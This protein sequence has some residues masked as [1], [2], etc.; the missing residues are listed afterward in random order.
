MQVKIRNTLIVTGLLL[1]TAACS[2]TRVLE[3]EDETLQKSAVSADS[4]LSGIPDYNRS[5]T[6]LKG[7]GRAIVSEPGNTERVKV[8][9]TSNR[10][11]SLVTIKNGLGI[12]GGRLLAHEDSMLIYNKVD[13]IAQRVSVTDDRLSSVNHLASVNI[14]DLM[15]F[16]VDRKDVKTVYESESNY[17][18][19]LKRGGKIFVDKQEFTVL[20]VDQPGRAGVPYSRIIYEAYGKIEGYT[21]PR[22][23]T[24]FSADARSKVA[25]LIQSLEINPGE[26]DLDIELPE[27]VKFV[28]Q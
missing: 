8:Y 16:T 4:I 14:V 27:D 24:I 22:R 11:R 5:L 7:N 17:I 1:T 12:E 9:F 6:S 21:I 25:L 10:S 23:V 13:N 19:L 3:M 26:L 20:Q 28:R 15:N 2:S 18:L